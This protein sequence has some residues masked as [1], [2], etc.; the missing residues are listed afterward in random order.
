MLC[1]VGA[2][3]T[4]TFLTY[5]L[6]NYTNTV[7]PFALFLKFLLIRSRIQQ[8]GKLLGFIGVLSSL[9][10]GGYVRRRTSTPNGPISLARAGMSTCALSL[11]LLTLLPHVGAMGT[12]LSTPSLLLYSAAAGL[13]F[14]SATVVNSLNALASLECGTGEV[15]KG[16]ALG[17]FRSR[18]Q[19]GRA[20][21]PLVATVVYW[22]WGPSWAYGMGAV[23][24]SCMAVK[25]GRLGTGEG[26]GRKEL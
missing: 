20:V 17:A 2:E 25:M 8:N 24:V 5:N 16:R 12:Y 4:L 18:G 9:L 21:G 1:S 22:V 3:F 26:K 13:A 6:F 23:G 19:L 15:E 14:V 10:Q 11:I 7:R